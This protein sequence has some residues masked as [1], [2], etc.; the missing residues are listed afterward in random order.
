[1]VLSS[2]GAAINEHDPGIPLSL[3]LDCTLAALAGVWLGYN[4]W[5][6]AVHTEAIRITGDRD[7]IPA[8]IGWLGVSRYAGT[9]V[10]RST[11]E[12]GT[13]NRV[14]SGTSEANR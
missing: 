14:G 4:P 9:P 2:A 11:A 8:I 12:D 1:M 13:H 10:A 7:A 6:H 3:R 5:L